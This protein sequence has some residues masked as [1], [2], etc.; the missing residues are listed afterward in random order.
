MPLTITNSTFVN[1][2]ALTTAGCRNLAASQGRLFIDPVPA[3]QAATSVVL[4]YTCDTLNQAGHDLPGRSPRLP[5]QESQ[6]AR[7]GSSENTTL[8]RTTVL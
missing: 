3:F 7:P 2:A 6:L 5:R 4:L 8:S 1:G